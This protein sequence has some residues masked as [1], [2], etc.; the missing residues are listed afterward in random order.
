MPTP[1][2]LGVGVI[3]GR[4]L[5]RR[6]VRGTNI[7]RVSARKGVKQ[8]HAPGHGRR[9]GGGA[10]RSQFP[11]KCVLECMPPKGG[12]NLHGTVGHPD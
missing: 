5:V 4:A 10:G 11:D 12:A 2:I 6:G 8:L 1:V 9:R 7:P 3:T